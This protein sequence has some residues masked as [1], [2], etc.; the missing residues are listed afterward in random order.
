MLLVGVEIPRNF[1][2]KAKRRWPRMGRGHW[3]GGYCLR[4][5]CCCKRSLEDRLAAREC[6]PRSVYRT[7]TLLEPPLITYKV[8]GTSCPQ[9][10]YHQSPEHLYPQRLQHTIWP[11]HG[12]QGKPSKC[13][14]R[15]SCIHSKPLFACH[16]WAHGEKKQ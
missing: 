1:V 3:M 12:A 2:A 10:I 6:V 5:N 4:P 9:N 7:M 14:D 8:S 13:F 16:V 15:S 11:Q